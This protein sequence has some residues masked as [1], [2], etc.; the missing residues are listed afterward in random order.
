MIVKICGITNLEDALW[1]ARAGAT[2]I[3]FVFY[4]RSPRFI[5]PEQARQI[6]KALPKE[7]WKVG[8]F[9]NEP[10]ERI[11]QI[12]ELVGLD[13]VQLHGQCGTPANARV[14][15]SVPVDE[16]FDPAALAAET[17]E[18]FVLDAP[19][20]ERY[21]GTGTSFDWKRVQGIRYRVV[22]AG[23]LGPDN[24]AEA[25]R[26]VRPWGVDASSRLE[27]YPGKKDPKKVEE[28]IRVARSVS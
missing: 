6:A 14:W 7:L 8:V 3:G 17:V 9:V 1:A 10:A 27:L 25:I 4:P 19:A 2:A 16:A 13:V 21:G 28:F 11:E 12:T 20:G 5:D 26:L 18:A 15:R 22:L 24:V 23:G